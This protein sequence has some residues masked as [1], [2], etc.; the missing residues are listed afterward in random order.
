MMPILGL[1]GQDTHP[2][3]Q[4]PDYLLNLYRFQPEIDFLVRSA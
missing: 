1:G 2:T 3:R 4:L